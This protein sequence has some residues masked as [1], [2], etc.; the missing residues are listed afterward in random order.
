M[1]DPTLEP[2]STR[3]SRF[4]SFRVLHTPVWYRPSVAPP[5]S[6]SA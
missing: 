2:L 4:R 5:L 1:M 6:S 3:G